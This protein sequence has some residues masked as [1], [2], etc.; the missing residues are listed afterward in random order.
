MERKG[1][2]N[3]ERTLYNQECLVMTPSH[4]CHTVE[5]GVQR[6]TLA[7]VSCQYRNHNVLH[8]RVLDHLI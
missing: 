7:D 1:P 5:V 2:V 4:P 6:E 3:E 8:C